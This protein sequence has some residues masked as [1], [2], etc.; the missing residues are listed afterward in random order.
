MAKNIE[1]K[2]KKI[3]DYLKL[4]EDTV[5]TMKNKKKSPINILT[6]GLIPGHFLL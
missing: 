2:L 4:E 5:F 6:Y 1:P 3:G